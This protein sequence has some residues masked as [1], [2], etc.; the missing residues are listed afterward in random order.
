[1]R[2]IIILSF[3]SLD[4][5]M[6][7]PGGPQEDTSGGFKFGGWTVPY[8]D[9]IAGEEMGRQMTQP[10]AL[11]LGRKRSRYSSTRKQPTDSITIKERFS[12]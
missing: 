11:L 2:K 8:F 4:G 6:Q 1:M 7:A 10:F 5:V 3:I 12:R 9:E